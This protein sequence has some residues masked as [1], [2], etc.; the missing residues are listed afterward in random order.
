MVLRGEGRDENRDGAMKGLAKITRVK[1]FLLQLSG[2]DASEVSKHHF[3][4]IISFLDLLSRMAGDV[5]VLIKLLIKIFYLSNNWRAKTIT[6][7]MNVGKCSFSLCC[8]K[9][10][11]SLISCSPYFRFIHTHNVLHTCLAVSINKNYFKAQRLG[12]NQWEAELSQKCGKKRQKDKLFINVHTPF[13]D[14]FSL[15]C[16]NGLNCLLLVFEKSFFLRTSKNTEGKGGK[17]RDRQTQLGER[18]G[19]WGFR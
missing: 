13:F 4:L 9:F 11:I 16:F 18:G 8:I 10:H 17:H 6:N 19:K 12:L 7:C 1:S 15:F 3:R 5:N 14:D 2:Q